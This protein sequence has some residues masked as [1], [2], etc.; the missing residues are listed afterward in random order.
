[1]TASAPWALD[2]RD[3]HT[4]YGA[5]TVL[6]GVNLTVG[7]GEIVAVVG[8]NGAGK[9]TLLRAVS[10]LLPI[11]QGRILVDGIDRTGMPAEDLVRYGVVHVPERRQLFMAMTVEENLRLGTY[12]RR[13]QA[14]QTLADDLERVFRLF[15]VLRERRRQLA[16]TLSGGEQQMVAIGRGL[17][18]A[19]RVLLL[20]EPSLGLAPL[21][22]AQVY[23]SI[24]QLRA[25]G[26]AILLVDENAEHALRLA[27]RA[28]VLINGRI[29]FEGEAQALRANPLLHQLYLGV[30]AA[31][32]PSETSQG[33]GVQRKG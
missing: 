33:T 14:R 21:I 29:V 20:D 1:M 30:S 23:E 17:M 22:T 7:Y 27:H 15:P 31:V 5:V 8:P 13:R 24:E 3:L 9:T 25:E 28:L 19:P 10:G 2:V 18:S 11:R 32:S 6:H 16:G 12:A 4:G 26:L